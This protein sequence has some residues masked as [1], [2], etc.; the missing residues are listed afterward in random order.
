MRL[1]KLSQHILVGGMTAFAFSAAAPAIHAQP[2]LSATSLVSSVTAPKSNT[3]APG[4]IASAT[5]A[6]LSALEAAVRPLS[7][8]RALENAFHAYFTYK[9]ERP[10]D[11]KKPFLYFVDYGL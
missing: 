7:S 10:Q 4:A 5:K 1:G 3:K 11:V 6:A 2:M 9:A 8:P